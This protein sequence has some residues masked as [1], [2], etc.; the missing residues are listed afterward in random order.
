[1]SV[2]VSGPGFLNGRLAFKVCHFSR[3]QPE[4]GAAVVSTAAG[5]NRQQHGRVANELC[6]TKR[7]INAGEL[8]QVT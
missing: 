2:V 6:H 4:L 8:A 1:M 5:S 7:M 3:P